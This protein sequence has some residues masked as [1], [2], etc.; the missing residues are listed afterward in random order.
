MITLLFIVVLSVS[1]LI[2]Y[3]FVNRNDFWHPDYDY[4]NIKLLGVVKGID[5][6]YRVCDI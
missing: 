1:M 6:R 5:G 4:G 2:I 3:E